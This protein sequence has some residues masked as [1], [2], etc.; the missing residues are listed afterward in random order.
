MRDSR[1]VV[2]LLFLT[3]YVPFAHSE[4][5]PVAIGPPEST[6]EVDPA[7]RR[8]QSEALRRMSLETVAYSPRGPIEHLVGETNIVLPADM[9]FRLAGSP[10][11]DVIPLLK[12]VLVASG[13]ETLTIKENSVWH[14]DVRNLEMVQSIRGTSVIYGGVSLSYSEKTKRVSSITAHFVPDRDLPSEPE[15]TAREAEEALRKALAFAEKL[16]STGVVIEETPRL[17]YFAAYDGPEPVHLVWA[18]TAAVR[19]EREEFLVDSLTGI[20]VYRR[21]LS[22]SFV[23]RSEPPREITGTR[24]QCAGAKSLIPAKP[25]RRLPNCG[26]H[27]SMNWSPLPDADRYVALAAVPE[28]G[29]VFSD[30]VI[31]GNSP[32][33]VCEVPRTAQIRMQACNSCG[34]GPWSRTTTVEVKVTCPV[35]R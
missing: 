8:R 32:Q 3:A 18:I 33:C 7:A 22:M 11:S 13:T 25:F 31:D 30:L 1:A 19:G 17:G 16:D 24:C 27:V 23:G 28:L 21:P 26:R 5:R 35:R 14:G 10:A 29:W 2:L 6:P 15:L 4:C 12:D 9:P 34:C 20:V